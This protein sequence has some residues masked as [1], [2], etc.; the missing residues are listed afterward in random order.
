VNP[1]PSVICCEVG[2]LATH[3]A[4]PAAAAS[5]LRGAEKMNGVG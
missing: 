2:S 1:Y 4:A 3:P 5:D